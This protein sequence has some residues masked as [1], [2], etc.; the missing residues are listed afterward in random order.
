MVRPSGLG[1]DALLR[2]L[3]G[4]ARE[5]AS[6]VSSLTAG[7]APSTGGETLTAAQHD[8]G[9]YVSLSE[10][11]S[12][13]VAQP[14]TDD[15]RPPTAIPAIT[16]EEV[17]GRIASALRFAGRMLDLVDPQQ[18]DAARSRPGPG[19]P[20]PALRAARPNRL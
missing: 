2:L 1:G 11:G 5:G 12:I 18:R 10:T 19:G 13:V 14:A 4:A 6:P 15:S 9:S 17:A 8:T 16:E 3:L 20:A 7:T